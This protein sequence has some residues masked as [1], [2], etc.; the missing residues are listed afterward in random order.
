[1]TVRAFI[2]ES[3]DIVLAFESMYTLHLLHD[4]QYFTI[5]SLIPLLRSRGHLTPEL[6][7]TLG[8]KRE[9]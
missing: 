8:S 7:D 9:L 4:D 5:R 2:S 3:F 6:L 1:M